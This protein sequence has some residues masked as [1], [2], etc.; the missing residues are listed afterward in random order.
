MDI[1]QFY[2]ADPRRRTSDE[3][4]FGRD[5]HDSAG[6]RFALSWVVDTGEL[7]LMREPIEPIEQD[8]LGDTWMPDLPTDA[9]TVEI[10]A[11]L[12]DRATVDAELDDWQTAMAKP[13]SVMWLRQRT[14]TS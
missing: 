14:S 6:T 2:D 3:V 8:P 7:Y 5:W 13:D 12:P 11:T 9:L 4:E 10:L 1:E